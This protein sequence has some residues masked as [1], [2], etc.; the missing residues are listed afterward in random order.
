LQVQLQ[1]AVL[2]ADVSN[3]TAIKTAEGSYCSLVVG[4]QEVLLKATA[5]GD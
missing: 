4:N 1:C 2:A 3:G 5:A